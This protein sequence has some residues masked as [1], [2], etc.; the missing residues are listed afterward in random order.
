MF[1]SLMGS[2]ALPGGLGGLG[3]S[4]IHENM[5]LAGAGVVFS[6]SWVV[7]GTSCN[8]IL[9]RSN[10]TLVRFW[11]GLGSVLGRSWEL[12]ARSGVVFEAQ[13]GE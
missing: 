13:T 11:G 5:L 9:G 1:C 10:G 2:W 8:G 3:G 6:W 7:L 4:K 12:L